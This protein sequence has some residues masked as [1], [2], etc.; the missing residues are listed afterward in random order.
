MVG[1]RGN[2]T[3]TG[4][5]KTEKFPLATGAVTNDIIESDFRDVEDGMGRSQW[6]GRKCQK[7]ER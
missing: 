4:K 2:G 7:G 6:V 5:G 1:K 3:H